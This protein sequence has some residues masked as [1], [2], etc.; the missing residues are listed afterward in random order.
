MYK[1]NYKIEKTDIN[2]G[3]HV[4]NERALMFFQRVR[5]KFL[6]ENNLEE[7]NIGNDIGIIQTNA[8]IEYLSQ[9]FLGDE[10]EIIISSV[11]IN[12]LQLIFNYE[13]KV[14]ERIS[15]KGYTTM[16]PYSYGEQKVKKLPEGFKILLENV[17]N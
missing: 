16:L 9:I 4:G 17:F 13:I 3:N 1:Y 10:I 8:Y 15:I 6:E 2:I 11:K 12:R 5:E 14:K 7:I